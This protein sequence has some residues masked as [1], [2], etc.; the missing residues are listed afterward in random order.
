LGI[1]VKNE[2]GKE[3]IKSVASD[4]PAQL[5]G[6][7][8]GNELLAIDGFKV[9]SDK[10]NDRLKLYQ[11]GQQINLTIFHADRLM[12]LPITLGVP[13]SQQYH[14]QPLEHTS[15]LQRQQ[16]KSWVS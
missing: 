7:D 9:T 11:P 16:F 5:A 3:I 13:R 2:H 14:V 10:L 6:V 4:S 1:I 8:A 15:D 12:T